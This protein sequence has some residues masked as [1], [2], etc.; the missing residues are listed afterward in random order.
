M[1]AEPS[2]SAQFVITYHEKFGRD[3][4]ESAWRLLAAGELAAILQGSL[5]TDLPL[6]ETGWGRTSPLEFS[7]RGCIV[8]D[9]S[10]DRATP[11]RGPDGEWLQ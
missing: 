2:L 6:A 1:R 9:E 3:V 4:P 10:P 7:P 8:R 11:T 5:A